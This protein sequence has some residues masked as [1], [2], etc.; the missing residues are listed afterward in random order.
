MGS[1]LHKFVSSITVSSLFFR[2]A[3]IDCPVKIC[4]RLSEEGQHLVVAE[5]NA[6]HNHD[7]SEVR[8]YQDVGLF[9]DC[10]VVTAI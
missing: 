3:R 5:V 8:V 4:L 10:I 7:V 9:M 1:K 2:T 6:S